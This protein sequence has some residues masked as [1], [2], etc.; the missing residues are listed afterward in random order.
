MRMHGLCQN[1]NQL[2]NQY[3]KMKKIKTL[4]IIPDFAAILEITVIL[5]Y[6]GI[7]P[8]SGLLSSLKNFPV[9]PS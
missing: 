4:N 2:K 5:Y 9:G 6:Q 3:Y 1:S 7:S 8:V